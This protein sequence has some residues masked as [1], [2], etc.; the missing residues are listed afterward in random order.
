MR[1]C[2]YVVQKK[3]SDAISDFTEAIRLD[4]DYAD[5]YSHRAA[6]YDE[7]GDADKAKADRNKLKKL[8]GKP[9]APEA[10]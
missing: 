4:D 7:T 5:A 10:E 3:W 1:A 9:D 6:A 2:A 8:E